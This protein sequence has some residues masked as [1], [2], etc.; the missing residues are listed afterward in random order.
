MGGV[1]RGRWFTHFHFVISIIFALL[2]IFW[3]L[4]YSVGMTKSEGQQQ[5]PVNVYTILLGEICVRHRPLCVSF[6]N[7]ITYLC[8]LF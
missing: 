3:V 7:E 1:S 8:H 4:L 2:D 5:A 6:D